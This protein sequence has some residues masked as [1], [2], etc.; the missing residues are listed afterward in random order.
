MVPRRI[1]LT[2][3][4]CFAILVSAAG[5][6]AV[7]A[8]TIQ[9]ALP[10]EIPDRVFWKLISDL[11]EKDGYFRFENFI[12]N[13]VGFQSVIPQ[14]QRILGPGGVYIGVG[15]EQNFTYV[16]A[17]QPKIAFIIDIRRQNMLEH[18]MYK[19]LF[20]LS[21]DRAEFLSNLLC[22]K[23]PVDLS[24]DVTAAALFKAYQAV[25]GDQHLYLRE[26]RAIKDVLLKKHKFHLTP[27]D[28]SKIEHVYSAFFQAGTRLDYSF[29]GS[30]STGVPTYAELMASTDDDGQ[31][32][33]Y[34]ANEENYQFVKSMEMKNLVI[35]LVG[36]FAGRKTVRKVGEY[37]KDHNA[38][39]T[40]F[41]TSNVE[42]YLFEQDNSWRMF[43]SN[44]AT[45]PL[46]RSS[47]FIRAF[48]GTR[49]SRGYPRAYVSV[50]SSVRN[51]IDG[52]EDG[53]IRT[54]SDVIDMSK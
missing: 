22:R 5:I 17:L 18:L 27:D 29:G 28:I 31:N 40:A 9:A 47:T 8:N 32:H 53:R 50:L 36:D 45:L 15:P 19:A 46:D 21:A 54:Y 41:Y 4:F 11:S 12:S 25:D 24:K 6:I 20:E 49:F 2:A 30:G 38:E 42:Q 51:V 37:L 52:V 26:L 13:E 48:N 3:C 10:N 43:Y 44:V 39:V 7:P 1:V 16:A 23:R 35:P 34:L 33:S 14:L